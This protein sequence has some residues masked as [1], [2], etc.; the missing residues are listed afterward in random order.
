M[1]SPNASV[2]K[3]ATAKKVTDPVLPI[4]EIWH[5]HALSLARQ[6]A[7]KVRRTSLSMQRAY[8]LVIVSEY[9]VVI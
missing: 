4:V 3:E 1:P 5:W 9:V 8:E 6:S 2:R 7:S